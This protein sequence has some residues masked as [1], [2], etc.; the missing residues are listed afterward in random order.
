MQPQAARDV[1]IV[2]Y[3][4]IRLRVFVLFPAP[5]RA[6][7]STSSARH[8]RTPHKPHRSAG[9]FAGWT[10]VEQSAAMRWDC[11]GGMVF[12]FLFSFHPRNSS[13]VAFGPNDITGDEKRRE[14]DG[15]KTPDGEHFPIQT[16]GWVW[17][18]GD[19]TFAIW[20]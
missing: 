12:S 9:E 15:H 5:H 3:S 20:P 18:R 10:A 7:R 19:L 4:G 8:R 13:A 17:L 16:M 1:F 14:T 11:G 6:N 2:G